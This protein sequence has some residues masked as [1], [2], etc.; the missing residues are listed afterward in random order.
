MCKCHGTGISYCCW[1]GYIGEIPRQVHRP[2]ASRAQQ[3]KGGPRAKYVLGDH[4]DLL[5][6]PGVDEGQDE[7]PDEAEHEVGVD[8]EEKLQA[9]G[10]EVL[11]N[12][13]TIRL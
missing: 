9:L 1:H 5:P 12:A 4:L 11:R 8:D 7:A 10:V 13:H 3:N 2:T 6:R